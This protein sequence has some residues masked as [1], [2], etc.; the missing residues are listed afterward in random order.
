MNYIKSNELDY[1]HTFFH[2]SRIS[3]K[4]SIEKN[5]LQ[6]VAGGE[7]EAGN[8][9]E[10]PTIYFSYGIDGMLKAI[11]V[12]IRW[13]Y[14]RLAVKNQSE[15][16][17]P[18]KSIDKKL[19]DKTYEKIYKDFK[20][21]MYFKVDLKEG[22]D[23]KTSDF[24]FDEIDQK[25]IDDYERYKREMQ[26][27]ET[28]QQKWK[29]VY[30]NKV[31]QWMYGSYSDFTSFKQDNWN[32]N[33]HIGERTISSNRINIIETNH[34]RTDALSFAIEAYNNYR[35]K[36]QD[37][38]LS[39]LDDFMKYAKELYKTD[40]DYAE[41]APDLGKRTI[42]KEEEQKYQKI[43]HIKTHAGGC[44]IS[45]LEKSTSYIKTKYRELLGKAID[46]MKGFDFSGR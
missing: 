39:R 6:A 16:I 25:K 8:D 7:N 38:D 28:G 15:Y 11:D 29:P 34:G 32:M 10:N 44:R 5:G 31:M 36:M 40:K 35:D 12:W 20:E 1:E 2:F 4:E 46:T 37:V 18:Y 26:K 19:M 41:D 22:E 3:N 33:T 23:S 30:P 14:N 17:P 9:K 13:E 42:I 43:N 27:Y 24:S 45:L 21:R